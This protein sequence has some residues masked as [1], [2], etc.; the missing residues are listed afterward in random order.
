MT[1]L[2]STTAAAYAD[3]TSSRAHQIG[4]H[5]ARVVA[6]GG[7]DDDRK[8]DVL[9]GLPGIF[10]AIDQASLG[11][12]YAAGL[13]QRLGQILVA[14]D[15][16]GDRAGA[17]GFGGPDASAACAVTELHEIA[18]GQQANG[19]NPPVLGRRRFDDAS[20][21]RPEQLALGHVGQALDRAGDVERRVVYR[22]QHEIATGI[23]ARA[24]H[25]LVPGAHD[26]LVD[27]TRRRFPCLAEAAVHAGQ[28]L[29]FER[30]VFEY[31]RRPGA[32]LDAP[33]KAAGL[34]VAAAVLAQRGQQSRQSLVEPREGVRRK[35]FEF[36]DI[37]DRFNDR[38]IGP[39]VRT[40]QV[41]DFKELEVFAWH[42]VGPDTKG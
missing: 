35:V 23:Q 22:C 24:G 10:D 38:S 29:Q 28:V 3:S 15:A 31:V 12:R 5:A 13:E 16:F 30:H 19:R 2:P 8:A 14:R 4:E 25:F 7:F 18:G 33:Q 32:F 36:A 42:G 39:H 40:A 41:A 6:V 37:D 1:P 27:A 26:D 11:D 34:A 21:A 17:V 20:G 9:G